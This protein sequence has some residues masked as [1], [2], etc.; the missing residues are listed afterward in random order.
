ML[1]ASILIVSFIV[2]SIPFGFYVGRVCGKIDIREHGS[3]NIGF[4]NVAREVG[5]RPGFIVLV[6]DIL[7]GLLPVLA[8]SAL[9]GPAIAAFAGVAAIAGH[10]F[11][12]FLGWRGGKGVATA[13]GAFFGLDPLAGSVAVVAWFVVLACWRYVSVASMAFGWALFGALSIEYLLGRTRATPLLI[14]LGL[15]VAIGIVITHRVNIAKLRAGTETK[16]RL[17]RG[18]EG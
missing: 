3:G 11:T 18:G 12:P 1:A 17:K 4:T 10:V 5:F 7:K 15:G 2:G 6:L 8:A 13:I 14:I 16:L 9:A